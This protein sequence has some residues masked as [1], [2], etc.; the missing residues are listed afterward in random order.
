MLSDLQELPSLKFGDTHL[1][2]E[3]DDLSSEMQEVARK[4]LRETPDRS[5]AAVD[6]LRALLKEDGELTVPLDNDEWMVRFL[7]PCKFYPKSAYELV[8]TDN[9]ERRTCSGPRLRPCKPLFGHERGNLQ[10]DGARAPSICL[11]GLLFSFCSS[12]RASSWVNY[13]KLRILPLFTYQINK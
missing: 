2:L 3:L 13:R 9:V 8:G 1:R 11:H 7:R 4:E 6:E 10:C 12:S 5:K